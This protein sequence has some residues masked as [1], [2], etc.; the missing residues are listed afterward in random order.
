MEKVDVT[1]NT[2]KEKGFL[3]ECYIYNRKGNKVECH[4]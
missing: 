3:Y 2:V 4:V 1:K